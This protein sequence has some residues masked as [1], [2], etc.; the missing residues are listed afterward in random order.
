[1]GY[2]GD[3]VDLGGIKGGME[4]EYN[5][6]IHWMNVWGSQRININSKLKVIICSVMDLISDIAA[7]PFLLIK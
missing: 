2:S 1:M 5:K 7:S 6:K 4:S 3:E